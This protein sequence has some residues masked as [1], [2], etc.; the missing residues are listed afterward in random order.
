V[1]VIFE[2]IDKVGKTTLIKEFG[3]KERYKSLCMDRG[4]GGY[5][6]YDSIFKRLDQERLRNIAS[7][8]DDINRVK[9]VVIY[10]WADEKTVMQRLKEN[11]EEYIY[12]MDFKSAIDMYA[13]IVETVYKNDVVLFLNTMRFTVA[14]CVMNIMDFVRKNG[15]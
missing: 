10:L 13:K 11:N 7:E 14:E 1:I 15:G 2:G 8:I 6:F 5:L 4:P 3:K 9:H 12:D